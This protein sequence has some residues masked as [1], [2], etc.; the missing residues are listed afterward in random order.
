MTGNG[1]PADIGVAAAAAVRG[2]SAKVHSRIGLTIAEALT[3][4]ALTALLAEKDA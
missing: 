4:L 3:G 2:E 1:L